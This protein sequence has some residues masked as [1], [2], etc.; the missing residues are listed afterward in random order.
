MKSSIKSIA[1]YNYHPLDALGGSEIQCEILA[2]GLNKRLFN[3]HYLSPFKINSPCVKMHGYKLIHIGK[4][5]DD[6]I[7]YCL[8]NNI[9][10]VYIRSY[11]RNCLELITKLKSKNITCIFAVS[12]L[13]D[14]SYK[15]VLDNKILSPKAV[16]KGLIKCFGIFT[17]RKAISK[18]DL[19]TSLNEKYLPDLLNLNDNVYYI[20]NSMDVNFEQKDFQRKRPY[21][22]WVA[23]LKD[24][25]QPDLFYRLAMENS[26]LDIDFIMVG[27]FHSEFSHYSY[28]LK[29]KAKNNFMY[30]GEKSP[31]E[32]N[33][34]MSGALFHVHT[35]K[36]EGFGNVFIQAWLQGRPS[37]SFEFD[38]G[39]CL[40]SQNIG[41]CCDG[42]WESFL[43]RFEE[44]YS[45]QN[46]RYELGNRAKDYALENFSPT[47]MVGSLQKHF[48]NTYPGE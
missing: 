16:I 41:F 5:A 13:H 22:I 35:C 45:S 48:I 30:L 6:M 20:P 21:C 12:A 19:I 42:N 24:V 1:L 2:R 3:V 36:P 27:R 9:G 26:H 11:K 4:E 8:K 33:V 34:I 39:G 44:L 40:T 32:V 17:T 43:Q 18:A 23:N 38:P 10:L 15:T 31:S 7:Q 28:L 25:K 37:L 14:F 47:K 46:L 29:D